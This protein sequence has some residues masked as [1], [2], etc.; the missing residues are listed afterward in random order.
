MVDWTLCVN[1]KCIYRESCWRDTE[2]HRRFDDEGEEILPWRQSLSHFEWSRDRCYIP[3]D[4][5]RL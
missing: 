4:G 2:K 1:E 5:K 3:V